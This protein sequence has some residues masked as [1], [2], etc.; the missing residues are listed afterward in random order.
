M[1]FGRK[2]STGEGRYLLSSCWSEMLA[3]SIRSRFCWLATL[4]RPVIT[5]VGPRSL[6]GSESSSIFHS[7]SPRSKLDLLDLLFK[8]SMVFLFGHVTQER[9]RRPSLAF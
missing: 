9:A 6:L 3:L 4:S 2:S 1:L 5:L 7:E 8:V